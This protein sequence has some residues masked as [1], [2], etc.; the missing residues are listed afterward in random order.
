MGVKPTTKLRRLM[1]D[2]LVEAPGAQDAFTARLVEIAD[3]EA[4]YLSGL[5]NA[6]AAI[7][8]PDLSFMSLTER[9]QIARNVVNAVDI[10][11]IADAEEGYG[12]AVNVMDTI[13]KYEQTGIAGCHIDDE[14]FPCRC[15]F[16]PGIPKNEVISVEQ[17]CGKVAAAVEARQDPDFVIIA[18]TNLIGTVS[19]DEFTAGNM[20]E[21]AIERVQAYLDAGADMAFLYCVTVDQLK[22]GAEKIKAPL[23]TLGADSERTYGELFPAQIFTD[24]GYRLIIYPLATLYTGAYGVLE[25][26]K[27]YR[28]AGSW[29][30]AK[31]ISKETFD[32]IVRTSDYAPLYEKFR[33]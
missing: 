1:A 19:K 14:L 27:S 3:F 5:T 22:R 29:Q 28:Q 23:M 11:V 12:N 10:P 20:I 16:L 4:V 17:M 26:L 9:L 18:R 2:K 21:Q 8:R 32:G 25:G 13:R 15:A 33:I 31:R 6:A 24:L 7:A 30:N